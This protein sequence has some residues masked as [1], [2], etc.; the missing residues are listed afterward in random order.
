MIFLDLEIINVKILEDINHQLFQLSWISLSL[1]IFIILHYYIYIRYIYIRQYYIYIRQYIL[2]RLDK[3]VIFS[4]EKLIL[5]IYCWIFNRWIQTILMINAHSFI[6]D[7]Y[8][9]ITLENQS[10][11]LFFTLFFLLTWISPLHIFFRI[12]YLHLLYVT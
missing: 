3:S 4:L 8:M 7:L 10:F 9:P 5:Y 11:F 6:K 2:K 1:L 12:S